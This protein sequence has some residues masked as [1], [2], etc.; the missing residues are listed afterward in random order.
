M[1]GGNWIDRVIGYVSPERGLRRA[2]ARAGMEALGGMVQGVRRTAASREGTL[3]NFQPS[4][5]NAYPSARIAATQ[6]PQSPC[7][8][9]HSR[10]TPTRNC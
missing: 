10:P 9:L 4:R 2:R 8:R 7:P 1:S 5:L 6:G 3:A